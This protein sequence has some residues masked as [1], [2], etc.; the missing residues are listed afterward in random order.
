MKASQA[1]TSG[2]LSAAGITSDD[3][4]SISSFESEGS[5]STSTGGST[6]APTPQPGHKKSSSLGNAL[7]FG[8]F[9]SRNPSRSSLAEPRD[10]PIKLWRE[11]QRVSLRAFIR[12]LLEDKQVANSEAMT[13][14]LIKNPIKLNEEEQL[15]VDR[16]R[17]MD[18]IRLEEQRKFYEVARQR[19]RELDVYMESF[20]KDIVESSM[21]PTAL[22]PHD[23]LFLFHD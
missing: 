18:E 11:N 6:R 10:Q 7:G 13:A 8:S 20:R 5:T 3:A 4:S 1:T 23:F 16:R 15:D 9:I 12:Q 19:A 22:I 14:F 17:A 21:C 2:Y